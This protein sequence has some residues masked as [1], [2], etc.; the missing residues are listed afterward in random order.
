MTPA[1][2]IQD[3]IARKRDGLALERSQIDSWI[4]GVAGGTVPEYQSA[5]LL[6]A[7][8]LRGMKRDETVA[9]TEALLR[10]GRTLDWKG[11]GRPTVDKH[12]T[13]GVGDKVSIALAPWV[14]SC[15]A[16]V[17]MLAG[18]GL[19]H[20]GGTLDKLEAIPGFRTR[21]SAAEFE[22]QIRRVGVAISGQSDDLAPADGALYALRDVTGTVESIPLIVSSIVSKKVATGASGIVFDV[23]CGL[24]AFMRSRENAVAL[25]RELTEVTKAL[26]RNARALVTAM[27]QPLGAAIGNASE[28]AEAID[29]L[30]QKAPADLTELTRTLGAAMLVMAGVARERHEAEARLDRALELGEAMRCAERFIQAQGGDPRVVTDPSRMKRAGTETKVLASTGGTVTALDGGALGRLLVAMGG[31]RRTKDDVVDGSVGIRLLRKVGDAVAPG[32]ALALIE[33]HRDAPDWAAIAGSA[34]TIGDRAVEPPALV[35]EDLGR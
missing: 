8:Y 34:Y 30:R 17:P 28:T 2:S 29:V 19:G 25:A 13:G 35:L 4:Q 20:T 27:D 22:S 33:A 10:S 31:G 9:L 7:V 11:V 14:A 15:G 3:A 6:M 16:M 18:R 5:A 21:L 12:S 24:A 26:G 1:H 32:E 23:K